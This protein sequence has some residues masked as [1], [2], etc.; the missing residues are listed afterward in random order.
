MNKKKLKANKMLRLSAQSERIRFPTPALIIAEAVGYNFD[1]TMKI[2]YILFV[3]AV[4]GCSENQ[5]DFEKY[6]ELEQKA[7]L[8]FKDKKYDK[9]L[10][11]F[12]KAIDLKPKEDVSIYFYAAASALNVG[13]MDKA[14]ELLTESIH[15][16]NAS[17]DYFL[18][19][20]EF[21]S[22]RKEKLFS[23]IENN[24][25]KHITEF[26]KKLEHPKIY[27]EVDSLIKLDQEIRNN[28]IDTK[29]MARIDSS[30]IKR[31]IKITKEYGWQN[32]GWLV[33][34]HQRETYE[35]DNYIWNFF[36]PYI[37]KQIKKGNIKKSF[38]TIFEE[39][40]SI[41]KN[42]EQIY[43]LYLNQLEQFPI[44]DIENID[45][46]RAQNG[47][48]PLWYLEKVYGVELPTEY[49]KL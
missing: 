3:L 10:S 24:Y 33:L 19:F 38:W 2:T 9:A 36:K 14:K 6:S 31:L 25:E 35:Q 45:K 21:D 46:R 48:P 49:K 1:K 17:K 12:Q 42:K 29:E 16:T 44:R 40:K 20:N 8:E 26:C 4:F 11:N 5:N 27:R 30:N 43:G 28:G 15:N 32:K 7:M 23:E 18:N 13:N 47:L 22:F 37:D 39:E 34:W 41:L